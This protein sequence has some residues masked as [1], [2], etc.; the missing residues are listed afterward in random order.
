MTAGGTWTI[1]SDKNKKENITELNYQEILRKI[2]ELPITQWNYKME[3]S[4]IR[5]I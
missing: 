5:H 2:D 1:P 4:S 3:D